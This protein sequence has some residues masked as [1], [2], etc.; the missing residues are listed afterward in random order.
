M[1][2]IGAICGDITT[3]R[4]TPGYGLHGVPRVTICGISGMCHTVAAATRKSA[5][6]VV[7]ILFQHFLHVARIQAKMV[8]EGMLNND[9]GKWKGKVRLH[10][11][12]ALEFMGTRWW[13]A[14]IA[15]CLEEGRMNN[16]RAVVDCGVM[17]LG[18]CGTISP[19]CACMHGE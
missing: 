9:K 4:R 18:S 7:V 3:D 1:L 8:T 2:P 19:R 11:A 14:L 16:E 10:C 12:M 17:F 6:V 15:M 5:A 13:E